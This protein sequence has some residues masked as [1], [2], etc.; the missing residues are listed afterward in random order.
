MGEPPRYPATDAAPLVAAKIPEAAPAG[1]L[2]VAGEPQKTPGIEEF[3]KTVE[4][5]IRSAPVGELTEIR[6]AFDDAAF[7]PGLKELLG[8]LHDSPEER[9]AVLNRLSF[10][11]REAEM[12]RDRRESDRVLIGQIAVGGGTGLIVGGIVA[13]LNPAF[14][15]LGFI[16]VAAGMVMGGFGWGGISKLDDQKSAYR[17]IAEKLLDILKRLE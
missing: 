17:Q 5:K 11:M 10:I 7:L 8:R 2:T 9:I 6:D 15:S 16:V 4:V 14:G 1:E 3:L 13:L 12:L